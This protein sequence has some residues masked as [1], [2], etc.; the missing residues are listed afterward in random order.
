MRAFQVGGD[1]ERRVPFVTYRL[2]QD[3]A[4]HA[5]EI[6]KHKQDGC[7]NVVLTP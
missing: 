1:S 4:P 2:P 7:I 6:F 5:Y 3:D